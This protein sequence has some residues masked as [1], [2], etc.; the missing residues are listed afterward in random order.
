[1]SMIQLAAAALALGLFASG[2]MAQTDSVHRSAEAVAGK[3]LRIGI[4]GNVKKD[5]SAGPLPELKVVTPPKHGTLAIRTGKVKTN[6]IANCPNLE[7]PIRGVFYQ[8]TAGY[9]GV[10]EISYEVRSAEG[11]VR[12]HSVRINVSN[13]PNPKAKPSEPTDL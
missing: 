10:D 11:K 6:R 12:S 13:Q 3:P 9:T 1:M 8:A 7:T 4:Y 2:T 5:C